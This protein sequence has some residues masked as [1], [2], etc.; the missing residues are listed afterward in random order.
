MQKDL[1]LVNG[2][3]LVQVLRKSG[4]LPRIVPQGAWDCVAEEMLL[5][6]AENGHPIFRSTTP[7][8]RGK[9]K[10]KG[11]GKVSIH[12]SAYQDTVDTIYRII[13]SVNQLSVYGAVAA[14]CDEYESHQDSTGQPVI[15]V[16]QSIVL[17]EIKAEV[18]AHDEEP[19]DDQ[20]ILQQYVQQVES[21]SPVNRVS[22]FCK[23]AGFMR[24]VEVGQYF[25]TRDA[26][27]FRQTVACR[28]Y[29]LPRDDK[30]SQPKRKYENWT[31]IGSHDQFSALQV[32]N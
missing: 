10:S 21:L 4:I 18:P 12:F 27:G 3:S 2:L 25:V 20:I 7:L 22:K 29:T 23:E 1:E 24:V 14:I 13:L 16:G 19:R 15:L 31:C 26:G 8:S 11:K 17:G 32:R 9:L 30:A 28:E 6:F 5:K